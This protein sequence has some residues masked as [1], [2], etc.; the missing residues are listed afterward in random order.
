MP[1]TTFVNGTIVSPQF[2]NAINNP[3]F[4]DTPDNDGEIAKITNSQLSMVA[5]NILPEWIAFRDE[6][7]VSASTGLSVT[8][9]SGRVVLPDNT[10]QSISAGTAA[11]ANNATNYVFVQSDGTIG[12]ATSLPLL[13][14]ALAQVTTVA[15]VISGSIVDLRPRYRVL[16]RANAVK[17]FGGNGDQGDYTLSSGSATLS[18][19]EYYYKSL[20]M[21]TA[22]TLNISQGARIYVAGEV[23]IAGTIV[24]SSI[25]RT[26]G[27]GG[28]RTMLYT[29]EYDF[30]NGGAGYGGATRQNGG[31]AYPY[32]V[33][34][35]GSGGASGEAFCNNPSDISTLANGGDAGG[36]FIIEAAG[37]ITVTGTIQARGGNATN[38]AVVS[39]GASLSG[40]GGGSGGLVL[41]KS[42]NS[43]VVSGAID[44]RGG[45]GT[46]GLTGT[47]TGGGGGGGGGRVVLISS[48]INTTGS[49]INLSGGAAGT[50]IGPG[51]N[52]PGGGGGGFGGAGGSGF[53]V[54]T[55]GS[56][57]AL[58]LRTFNA[59]A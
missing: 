16:P 44:V 47:S 6:L 51:A 19:G 15:G 7:K 8:Y 27:L 34:A 38:P 59:I 55:A 18:D 14:F 9:T 10:Y 42:L 49:T 22:A 56:I 41:L 21:G 26:G 28:D 37:K 32:T 4:V 57:G 35:V 52:T 53:G 58:T 1:K 31:V 29:N 3:V 11:L 5:G 33:A 20:T 36:F 50:A 24:V 30:G 13:S 23:N 48:S 12:V 54:P 25:T 43:I 17:I 45:S 2:L 39:G 40:G 46:N